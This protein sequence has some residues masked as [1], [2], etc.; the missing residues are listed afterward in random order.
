MDNIIKIVKSLEDLG[1]LIHGVSETT[2]HEIKKQE[3]GLLYQ[4]ALQAVS[5]IQPLISSVVKGIT[6]GEVRRPGR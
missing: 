6:G 3:D 2:K 1:I 4:R 5:L